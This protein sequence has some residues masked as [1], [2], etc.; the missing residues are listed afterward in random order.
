MHICI[1]T[2]IHI[3]I[4]IFIQCIYIRTQE[5]T[6]ENML[7][8][9]KGGSHIYLS[10]LYVHTK[11]MMDMYAYEAGQLRQIERK[12]RMEG[13]AAESDYI[14]NISTYQSK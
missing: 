7:L 6:R 8:R 10:F 13:Y 5:Q 4:Y 9:K 11:V 2:Y 14:A 1:Y 3:Y 12:V